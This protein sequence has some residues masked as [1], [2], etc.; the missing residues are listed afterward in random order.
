M[1]AYLEGRVWSVCDRCGRQRDLAALRTEWTNL[2][3]CSRCYDTRP[4]EL[5]PPRIDPMEGMPVKEPRPRPADV[6]LEDGDVDPETS[7]P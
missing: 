1:T 3:V 7:F 2:K 4:P 5:D 6:F